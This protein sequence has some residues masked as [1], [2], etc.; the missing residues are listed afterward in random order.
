MHTS[1][2]KPKVDD[3]RQAV[4]FK[5]L[6]E[7][8]EAIAGTMPN[9]KNQ[10]GVVARSV[11]WCGKVIDEHGV[12]RG[13]KRINSLAS[14]AIPTP[15]VQLQQFICATNWM[16]GNFIAYAQ[17][18]LPPNYYWIKLTQ[19]TENEASSFWSDHYF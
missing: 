6:N 5:L 8:T 3:I 2:L 12:R 1:L 4:C 10:T 9:L 18:I 7:M 17:T 19:K 11:T 13:L 16:C 14:M 15:A